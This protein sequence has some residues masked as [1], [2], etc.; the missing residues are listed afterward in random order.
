MFRELIRF[1][2]TRAY[3]LSKY[4]DIIELSSKKLKLQQFKN[5]KNSKSSKISNSDINYCFQDHKLLQFTVEIGQSHE[6]LRALR[7]E[8]LD[9][10]VGRSRQRESYALYALLSCIE[11]FS[12]RFP[13]RSR[14]YPSVIEG[15]R[16]RQP[17]IR[18]I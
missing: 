15:Q 14:I 17:S 16:L 2:V 18:H 7:G 12:S 1:S 4:F 3:K 8:I 6:N 5:L 13:P 11:A 10:A 9:Q